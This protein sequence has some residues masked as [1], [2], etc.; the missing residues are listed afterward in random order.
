MSENSHTIS[1]VMENWKKWSYQK[2][3]HITTGP[4]YKIKYKIL[5]AIYPLAQFLFWISLIFLFALKSEWCII[6]L[7]IKLV[8]TYIIYFKPMKNLKTFDLYWMH[9]LHEIFQLFIQGFFVLL[10]L[11]SNPKK[12]S[13]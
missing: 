7:C 1:E 12:W 8:A 3:R 13:R 2:R 5:L 10:N 9:P 6:L 4:L 11:F